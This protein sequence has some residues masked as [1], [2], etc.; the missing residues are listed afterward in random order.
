VRSDRRD[1]TVAKASLPDPSA[2]QKPAAESR[3]AETIF[4]GVMASPPALQPEGK[5]GTEK[6]LLPPIKTPAETPA[7]PEPEANPPA[8]V[9]DVLQAAAAAK[10]ESAP[11]AKTEETP[12]AA[13]TAA[14]PAARPGPVKSGDLVDL[15]AVDIPPALLNSVQPVYPPL[16]Y[17]NKQQAKVALTVLI[18]EKG[19]ILEAK[20]AADPGVDLVFV[21]AAQRAVRRWS[22]S[23]AFKGGVAVRVWK[24]LIIDFRI[25]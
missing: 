20:P 18:S 22:Y 14:E 21:K 5:T 15:T 19:E 13:K 24:T 1:A 11:T 23:P 9:K 8:V 3:P 6:E 16:A 2:V 10:D 17:R 4:E 25:R 12:A 7:K